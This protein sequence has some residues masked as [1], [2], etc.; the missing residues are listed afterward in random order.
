MNTYQFESVIED[1]GIIVLPEQMKPLHKHRVRLILI[2]LDMFP[3]DPV[4]QLTQITRKY[5]AITDEAELPIQA[6]ILDGPSAGGAKIRAAV[7]TDHSFS[8]IYSPRGESFTLDNS[9]IHAQNTK[10][11]WFDPRYGLSYHLHTGDTQGIQT[12]T[13]PTSGKG[14]D[15]ILILENADL[16][17]PM[18]GHY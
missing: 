13:P 10:A 2:D 11:I 5:L 16:G 12:Y 15:W 4:Q 14:Q 1:K 8:I 18:P 7:A 9:H 17:M 6:I 3:P